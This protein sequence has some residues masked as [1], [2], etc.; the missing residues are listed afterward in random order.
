MNECIFGQCQ[1]DVGI[2]WCR[3]MW[4]L[5]SQELSQFQGIMLL[6]IGCTGQEHP[7]H[8]LVVLCSIISTTIKE[9]FSCNDV[10]GGEEGRR[11]G[12]HFSRCG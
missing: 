8:I 10:G 5:G 1:S 7:A 9:H 2:K 11:G 3:A 6:W 12:G 4:I